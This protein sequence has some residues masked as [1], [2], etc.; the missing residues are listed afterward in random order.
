[1]GTG[2]E[3]KSGQKTTIIPYAVDTL[4]QFVGKMSL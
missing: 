3:Q 1:M 4:T 2:I